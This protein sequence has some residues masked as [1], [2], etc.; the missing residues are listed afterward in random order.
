MS[1]FSFGDSPPHTPD[2]FDDYDFDHGNDE[3]SN[4]SCGNLDFDA[5]KDDDPLDECDNFD[6]DA[7]KDDDPSEECDNF[8]YDCDKDD[9]L[10]VN[11]KVCNKPVS[12]SFLNEHLNNQHK[13][14]YC[15]D[16]GYM[17]AESLEAHIGEK[18]MIACKHCD[19]KKLTSEI[20]QH[21]LSHPTVGMIQLNQL[22]DE[23]F[24]Q[25]VAENRIYAMEGSLFV[26]E[27]QRFTLSEQLSKVEI[28]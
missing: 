10:F 16:Y 27:P 28:N 3:S 2:I 5:D 24:N 26:K 8:D 9:D 13:C 20:A 11:C 18:H 6:F 12:S 21:E 22:T 7:D 15:N 19:A 25:L 1:V 4:D 14:N 23:R 17:N